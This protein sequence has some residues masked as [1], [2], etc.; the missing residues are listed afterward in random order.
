MRM[1]NA[2]DTF[3]I[4]LKNDVRECAR[5][6]AAINEFTATNKFP[7]EE[8]F[9]LQACL[10]EAVMTIVKQGFD[11]GEE[12]DIDIQMLFQRK[13]RILTIRIADDGKKRNACRAS[14][15]PDRAARAQSQRRDD[16]GFAAVYGYA[17]R[18]SCFRQGRYNHFILSR[19]I[20]ERLNSLAATPSA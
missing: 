6:R 1:A 16:L 4:V 15:P 2:T 17:D 11:D 7:D 19:T 3:G 14:A 10:Q 13:R 20:P 8:G 9:E 12:H 18:V 5:L